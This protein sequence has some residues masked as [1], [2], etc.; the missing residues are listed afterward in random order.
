[1]IH[2]LV[3]SMV[4][5]AVF[6]ALWW[7]RGR[8]TSLAALVVTPLACLV[9]GA[10]AVVPDMPRLFGDLERYVAWHHRKDCNLFWGHCYID[11]H[12]E[13][14]SSMAFPVLFVIAVIA[15]FAVGWYELVR[16]ERELEL[17]RSKP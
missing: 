7:R 10:W 9:S 2:V 1:M 8:R 6:F 14:D 13:I 5:L 3:A 15:V 4:P 16:R 12:D 17:T 11:A